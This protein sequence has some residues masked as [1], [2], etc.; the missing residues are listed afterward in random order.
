VDRGK[1]E[2]AALLLTIAGVLLIMP[3]LVQLFQWQT[4][5][6]GVPIE[7]IYLFLIWAAMVIGARGLAQRMPPDPPP[8]ADDAGG[9]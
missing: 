3:P 1:L 8:P 2:S 9:R 6:F 4:R 5:F 7:V